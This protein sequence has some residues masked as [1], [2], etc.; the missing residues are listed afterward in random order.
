MVRL[1]LLLLLA[2]GLN[3]HVWSQDVVLIEKIVV[4]QRVNTEETL[5]DP[6]PNGGIRPGG[7]RS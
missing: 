5:D 6:A 1:A 4:E 7:T 2:L 3:M